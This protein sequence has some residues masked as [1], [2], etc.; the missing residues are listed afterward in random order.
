MFTIQENTDFSSELQILTHQTGSRHLTVGQA[1]WKHE[2]VFLLF[3]HTQ[4][5][6]G[7]EHIS[8]GKC[9]ADEKSNGKKKK[10]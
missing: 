8:E 2:E 3:T 5:A 1:I 4:L 7:E 9:G 10:N 6:N